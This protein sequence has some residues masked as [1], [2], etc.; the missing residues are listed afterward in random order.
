MGA[1]I[2][3]RVTND[4]GSAERRR[5]RAVRKLI[6]TGTISSLI[7]AIAAT[8]LVFAIFGRGFLST[9]N[10]FSISQIAA[11]S[12]VIGLANLVCL[13]IG[14]MNLAV[15][16]IG[17]VVAMCTGWL[18]GS[19]HLPI[20][21]ALVLGL[22]L[23][24]AAGWFTGWL[25]IKTHLNALIV[26]VAMLAVYS[27]LVVRLSSGAPINLPA[28]V[29]GWSFTELGTPYLSILVLPAVVVAIALWYLYNRTSL[30]RK[31]LAVGANERAATISG[32]RLTRAVLAA[33]AL[34]G[35]LCAVA[36]LMETVRFGAALPSLG[37]DWLLPAFIIP[38][39]G[40]TQLRGGSVSIVG[41][42]LASIF[43]MSINSGLVAL[44]VPTFWLPF[45]QGLILVVAVV[46]DERRRHR[47]SSRR[48]RFSGSGEGPSRARLE[49]AS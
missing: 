33:F 26:T 1:L 35:F 11:S 12:A 22:V 16:G 46:A 49:S 8:W 17:V 27:G 7:I 41:T 48:L 13:V 3:M 36:G 10:L 21:P 47:S 25:V 45:V 43:L 38:V 24:T 44:N 29:P 6:G 9:Y 37:Q 34:S 4:P 18:M 40:G 32:V 20:V 2:V 31:M 23:G 39:L 14:R 15:G 19:G 42:V 5:L 28:Q 30:G